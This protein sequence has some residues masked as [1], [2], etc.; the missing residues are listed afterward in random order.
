MRSFVSKNLMFLLILLMLIQPVQAQAY[1]EVR[2]DALVCMDATQKFEKKYQI[3]EHLLTTISS[4]ETGRW[5]AK[6]KQKVAWPWTVNAQ[7]KGT[8][9]ETKAQAV[10]EVKRLQKRVSKASTSVVCKLT[11]HITQM[12]SRVS[13]KHLT[14]K[15]TLN[16]GQNF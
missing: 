10:R 11:W 15:K 4:V 14:P 5:N 12:L 16:T 3:K 8:Y 9:F 13:K 2:D 7:G 6:T 1:S